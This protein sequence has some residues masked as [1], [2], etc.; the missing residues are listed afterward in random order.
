MNDL[1]RVIQGGHTAPGMDGLCY[2]QLK[3]LDDLV[4]EEVLALMNTVWEEG[5]LPAVWKHAIV[6][7]IVK[8]GK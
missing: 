6:V 3:H 7:P 8:P 4:L 1:R 2:E 5:A